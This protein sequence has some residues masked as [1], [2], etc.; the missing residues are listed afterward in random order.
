LVVDGKPRVQIFFVE[1]KFIARHNKEHMGQQSEVLLG[2]CLGGGRENSLR[3]YLANI[4]GIHLGTKKF[5]IFDTPSL[6]CHPLP[7]IKNW[8]YIGCHNSSFIH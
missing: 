6:R 8:V 1:L 7:T 3:T 4:F 2:T 5:E